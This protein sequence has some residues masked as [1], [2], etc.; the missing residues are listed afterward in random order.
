MKKSLILRCGLFVQLKK[1]LESEAHV[2]CL[3]QALNLIQLVISGADQTILMPL[4]LE[5][6]LDAIENLQYHASEI[7]Y[8][9]AKDLILRLDGYD[10]INHTEQIA[11]QI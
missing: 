9:K 1:V 4:E 2:E 3:I 11:F 7:I 8:K 5:G 6:L 10:E